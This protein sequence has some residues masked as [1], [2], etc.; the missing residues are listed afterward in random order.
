M[1]KLTNENNIRHEIVYLDPKGGSRYKNAYNGG[2]EPILAYYAMI[3][4]KDEEHI[5]VISPEA[6]SKR[7]LLA[8][9]AYKV[10]GVYT[11]DPAVGLDEG[12]LLLNDTTASQFSGRM[13]LLVELS[14]HC[15]ALWFVDATTEPAK[16][17]SFWSNFWDLDEFRDCATRLCK[18]F[19]NKTDKLTSNLLAAM[20][21]HE[22]E[23][24]EG[25]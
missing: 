15:H 17:F 18:S 23:K 16:V 9:C 6:S 10:S 7:I 13:I 19:V 14:D 3:Q 8:L 4:N 24:K 1:K 22:E 25:M 2:C 5:Q 11:Q 21:D 12:T 20:K